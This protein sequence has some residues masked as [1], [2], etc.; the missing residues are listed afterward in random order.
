MRRLCHDDE[1]KAWAIYRQV[2][3]DH[4]EVRPFANIVHAEARHIEALTRL[5]GRYGLEVPDNPWVGRA[6]RYDSVAAAC[7]AGVEAEIENDALYE[8][9]NAAT[10]RPDILAVFARLQ[11]ASRERH[12]PAFQRCVARGGA[13]RGPGGGRGPGRGRGRGRRHGGHGPCH[14]DRN[15]RPLAREGDALAL[16]DEGRDALEA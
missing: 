16:T 1:H 13:G 4:G 10:D 7:A 15:G 2:L 5:F 11:E 3:D 8:R 9:L 12:L 14:D 6:P